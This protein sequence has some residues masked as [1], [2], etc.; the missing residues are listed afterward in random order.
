[1]MEVS[2]GGRGEP[3]LRHEHDGS[4]P[5]CENG[6]HCGEIDGRLAGAGDTVEKSDGELAFGGS[7]GDLGERFFLFS[8]EFEIVNG[9]RLHRGDFEASGFFDDLDQS[10][11]D[12]S[13]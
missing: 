7:G 10:A 11:L 5:C 9:T 13:L 8:S 6:F 12:E 4:L 2:G 3:D 1:M